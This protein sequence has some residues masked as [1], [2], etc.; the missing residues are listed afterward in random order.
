DTLIANNTIELGGSN[1]SYSVRVAAGDVGASRNIVD[2]VRIIGNRIT[3]ARPGDPKPV[4]VGIMLITGDSPTTYDDPTYRPITYPDYNIIRNVWIEDNI[5]KGQGERGIE[6][7]SGW[8]GTK[9][10]TIKDVFVLGNLVDIGLF[11]APLCIPPPP[12]GIV[13]TGGTSP[14]GPK[15]DTGP[16]EVS[17]ISIQWNTIRLSNPS[18]FVLH[19]EA[20][21]GGGVIIHHAVNNVAAGIRVS[22]NDIAGGNI[23][24]IGAN[25][26]P[27]MAQFP[28]FTVIMGSTQF[29]LDTSSSTPDRIDDLEVECNRVVG[30]STLIVNLQYLAT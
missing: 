9:Y 4:N 27:G 17:D 24:D 19:P 6:I 12:Y 28:W 13:V 14:V 5:I 8:R 10:N 2:G 15:R 29:L 26:V 20:V 25:G 3:M 7:I 18:P 1:D 16:N 30:P 21:C 22:H 11:D 23:I